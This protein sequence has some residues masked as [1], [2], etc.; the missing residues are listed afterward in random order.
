MKDT[1]DLLQDMLQA[2]DANRIEPEF[3]HPGT[4][5]F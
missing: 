3:Q 5:L 1:R 2:I 4:D